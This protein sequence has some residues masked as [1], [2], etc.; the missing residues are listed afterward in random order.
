LTS[1]FVAKQPIFDRNQNIFGYELLYRDSENNAFPEGLSDEQASARIFY[2]TALFHGITYITESK[3]A[4]VNLCDKSVLKKLPHLVP[5]KNLVVEIV[6]RSKIDAET[7]ESIKDLHQ[8]GYVFAL[9]D[10][11]FE[12]HWQNIAPYMHFVKFDIPEV[13]TEIGPTV[14]KIRATFPNVKLVAERVET[15]KQLNLAKMHGVDFLQGYFFSKP[16]VIKFTDIQPSKAIAAELITCLNE[17]LLDFN[18]ISS[19]LSRDISLTSRVIKLANVSLAYRNLNISSISK[20]V[21]YLGEET[22]RQ[23]ISIVAVS[24]LADGK[25]QEVIVLGLT[26]AI[27]ISELP[28]LF[29][30]KSSDTGFLIGLLSVLDA[31]LDMTLENVV[32]KLALQEIIAETL[33]NHTGQWGCALQLVIAIENAEWARIEEKLKEYSSG[34]LVSIDDL[35]VESNHKAEQ[36]LLSSL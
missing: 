14:Q 19:I 24:Q 11:D 27:F 36:L 21:I 22:M 30:K 35:Y 2:E 23:F 34:A 17:P 12:D 8:L 20:A 33:L 1:H 16:Q 26:R 9:D 6:E 28:Q 13:L 18:K 29:N 10:Y 15:Q 7:I 32:E 4:F 5:A 25:P 31:I 3:T